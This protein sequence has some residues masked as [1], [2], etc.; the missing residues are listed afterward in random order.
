MWIHR[1]D[2]DELDLKD[3]VFEFLPH[4]TILWSVKHTSFVRQLRSEDQIEIISFY[5]P[6]TLLEY[7]DVEQSR[8][9]T[10]S[11]GN[12]LGVR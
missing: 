1:E 5:A 4:W 9:F 10:V 2:T 8:Y 11:E 3:S 6:Q 12:R 7:Y